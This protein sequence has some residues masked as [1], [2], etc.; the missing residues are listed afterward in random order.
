MKVVDEPV[1][2][3]I[4]IWMYR[5]SVSDEVVRITAY[6]FHVVAVVCEHNDCWIEFDDSVER[7]ERCGLATCRLQ[8]VHSSRKQAFHLLE[9]G[10]STTLER[11]RNNILCV[12]S[13]NLIVSKKR[14]KDR[15]ARD[16]T[17]HSHGVVRIP[18][19]PS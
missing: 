9:K 16:Q 5:P 12:L 1:L 10:S 13:K 6:V 2:G 15:Q 4:A 14:T 3:Q 19:R 17:E 11:S 8:S 7:R 18:S